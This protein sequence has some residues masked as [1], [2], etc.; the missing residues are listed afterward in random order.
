M[1][2]IT[3]DLAKEVSTSLLSAIVDSSDD[4]IISK[5]LNGIIISWNKTAERLFGYTEAEAV[6]QSV[7]TLLIPADRQEEEPEILSRLRRGERVDHF[8]TKRKH[9]DGSLLDV[10]LTISPIKDARGDIVGASKIARD[11]TDRQQMER[12]A[13]LLSA[14]VDSS[15]DAIIS[16][17]LNGIITSWNKSAE[18]LFGYTE[19][20]AVGQSVATL[21]I[22]ADRQGE[23]PEILSRLRRG[24]RVDHFE[25]K[26]RHKKGT[27]VDIS[28]TISPIRNARGNIIGASKIARDITEQIRN[29]EAL[30]RANK[31]LV[32]LNAD[33][34]YFA[35][36]ASHD[37]QEPLRM[38]SA[39]SGML[40]RKY[41][42]ELDDKANRY[43]S[44]LIEG[45]ARMERLLHDLR[46][47]THV[48]THA[49]S[50]PEIDANAVLRDVLV[51]LKVAIDESRAEV[52]SGPL[53]TVYLHQFQLGQLFQ[54]I[55]GNA[56]RYRSEAAPRIHIK[57]ETDGDAWRFSVQDNGIGIAAEYKEKIFGMFTRLHTAADYQGTGMGLAICQRIVE[58]VGGSI[59]VESQLGRGSTF[60]FTLPAPKRNPVDF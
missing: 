30:E 21:L 2:C 14:I 56:I 60:F 38:V 6:G 37:L 28:L 22:P 49:E 26:R 4:A 5:D 25:T 11:I 40:R 51:N 20:E 54:N 10:S 55:I 15:D 53:P 29:R 59:C 1:R 43:L 58:R 12:A 41:G 39:Y 19:A 45:S 44:Y 32:Q 50:P 16:K 34:E 8:E 18:R 31:H 47:F 35:Y 9:K 57:A 13:L 27:L 23:E 17:D 48:S 52:T 36:S 3:N 7:A 42:T 24:Q 33:L 46:A